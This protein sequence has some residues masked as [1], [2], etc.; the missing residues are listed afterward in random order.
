MGC[1]VD[2]MP[3]FA[4]LTLAVAIGGAALVVTAGCGRDEQLLPDAAIDAAGHVDAASCGGLDLATCRRTPGC[5]A[6][7]CP[8]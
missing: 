2:D 7:L 5:A 6:D 3:S 4:A 1:I 8:G